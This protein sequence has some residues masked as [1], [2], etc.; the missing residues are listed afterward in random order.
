MQY[1]RSYSSYLQQCQPKYE[2]HFIIWVLYI[3]MPTHP[4]RPF[5]N[6][7]HP[8][9]NPNRGSDGRAELV[10]APA[11]DE[12]RRPGGARPRPRVEAG[13]RSPATRQ[14]CSWE[15]RPGRA[16][17][18][19]ACDEERRPGGGR[20]R[21]CAVTG[22]TERSSP[23]RLSQRRRGPTPRRAAGSSLRRPLRAV[24]SRCGPTWQ[25]R[26]PI[27]SWRERGRAFA[28]RLGG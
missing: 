25:R 6:S 5:S 22:R 21:G 16:R 28:S 24:P 18:A 27:A 19:P 10:R 2:T 8:A 3:K 12:E 23:R 26:S 7:Q 4:N 1:Q 20:L 11:C 14:R 15:R 13:R 9:A 17:R